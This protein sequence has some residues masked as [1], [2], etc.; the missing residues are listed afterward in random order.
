MLCVIGVH[1]DDGLSDRLTKIGIGGFPHPRAAYG[2][3]SLTTV[4][5][6]DG[7][8]AISVDGLGGEAFHN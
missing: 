1:G 8:L 2:V 6:L 5:N 7:G 3:F 4:L